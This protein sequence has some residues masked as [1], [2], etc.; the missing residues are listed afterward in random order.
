MAPWLCG[1]YGLWLYGSMA[2]WPYGPMACVAARPV[3]EYFRNFEHHF[4]YNLACRS[5]AFYGSMAP[6][7]H[8]DF[9]SSIA[10]WL[11][12]SMALRLYG[13]RLYGSMACKAPW[14]HGQS[15][16]VF[17]ILSIGLA[18]TQPAAAEISCFV[19]SLPSGHL[20]PGPSALRPSALRP[21]TL[22]P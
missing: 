11:Y 6:R 9:Y 18:M 15:P 21:S 1:S 12:G 2:L 8:A 19:V 4:A 13:L 20:P 7:L 3:T 17:G 5:S 16:N 14:L 22:R 10:L